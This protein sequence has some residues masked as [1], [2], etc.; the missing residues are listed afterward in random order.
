MLWPLQP[1]HEEEEKKKIS[2]EEYMPPGQLEEAIKDSELVELSQ[3]EW[4]NVQ[5]HTSTHG[6]AVV[7][8]PHGQPAP[9][10]PTGWGHVVCEGA[11]SRRHSITTLR[12][13]IGGCRLFR[14]CS[15]AAR[16]VI[17]L[18]EDKDDE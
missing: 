6:D 15:F 11:M 13:R 3:W 8:P 4:L 7:P 9:T 16:A 12:L 14:R 1:P 10:P 5:L 2:V 17:Y 18:T